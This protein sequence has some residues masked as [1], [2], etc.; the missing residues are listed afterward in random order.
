MNALDAAYNGVPLINGEEY[1]WGDIKTCINGVQVIGIVAISDGD[2]QDKQNNYGA[3]RHPC[4]RS[5]APIPPEAKI[6]P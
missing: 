2:K 1:A 5:P 4:S 3:G 6:T